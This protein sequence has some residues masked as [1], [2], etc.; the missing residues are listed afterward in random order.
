MRV[1]QKG[2]LALTIVLNALD[3]PSCGAVFAVT[4]EFERRRREDGASF[5]CPSGHSM[6]YGDSDLERAKKDAAAQ[7]QRAERL[8]KRLQ[9]AELEVIEERERREAVE[10]S[11]NA[12]KGVVTKMRKRSRAGMCPV[13]GCRRHFGETAL[14]KHL[15]TVHP[16]WKPEDETEP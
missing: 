9:F 4:D 12:I 1:N 14:T 6:S 3:C 7:K 8:G 5:Y 10:R 16:D 2:A 15:A 11:R 13:P